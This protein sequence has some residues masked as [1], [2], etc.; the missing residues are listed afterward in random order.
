MTLTL[1]L[2]LPYAGALALLVATPGPVVAAL[3]ARAAT[4]GVAASVPLAAGVA[5]GDVLWP[6]AAMLGIGVVAGVWADALVLLR[7]LGAV[8]LVWMGVQL[9]RKAEAA[10]RRATGGG[11]ARESGWAGFTAG[12]LVIAGNPKA[13]LFYLGVLPGFFDMTSLTAADVVVICLVSALVPFLGNLAWA[14]VFARA[15]ILLADP[16]AMRRVHV[17]AGLALVG[18]GVAIALG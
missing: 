9:V 11:L 6:L 12:L 5:V 15:R 3:I 4:G 8:I 2:L 17:A 14:A 7:Y 18:V 10:A 16:V 1:P 13:I